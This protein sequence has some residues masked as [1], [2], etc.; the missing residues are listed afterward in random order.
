MNISEIIQKTS[1]RLGYRYYLNRRTSNPYISGDSFRALFKNRIEGEKPNYSANGPFIFCESAHVSHFLDTHAHTIDHN[2]ILI[3]GNGDF[4]FNSLP[5]KNL[6]PNMKHWFGQNILFSC[7]NCTPLPIGLENRYFMRSGQ[8]SKIKNIQKKAYLKEPVI[9]GAFNTSNNIEERIPAKEY[10]L[11]H[12]LRREPK[13]RLPVNKFQ[14]EMSK[15]MFT[16]SPPGNG[17]DCHRTWEALYFKTVPIVKKSIWA[18]YFIN[19][20][21]P[22]LAVNSWEDLL[23][24]NEKFLTNWY[25]E[26]I[27]GFSNQALYMP[28]WESLITSALKEKML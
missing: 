15:A 19:L 21:L 12:P 28:Y 3:S 5:V 27:E 22:L 20:G 18:D 24:F 6:P 14:H 11:M 23:K 4:N 2:F 16:L 17:F 8:I 1:A 9:F 10:L 7:P 26:H 25:H 13:N